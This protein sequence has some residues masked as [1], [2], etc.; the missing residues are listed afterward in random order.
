MKSKIKD[1]AV[2]TLQ[3]FLGAAAILL[4]ETVAS[5]GILLAVGGSYV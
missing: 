5:I 1:V 3:V 4:V 2:K